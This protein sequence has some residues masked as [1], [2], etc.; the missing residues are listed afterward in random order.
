LTVLDCSIVLLKGLNAYLR[1]KEAL[2]TA[3]F[4]LAHIL[5][6]GNPL[7]EVEQ[8]AVFVETEKKETSSQRQ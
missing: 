7:L 8:T 3:G 4:H 5:L 1:G 6:S 2:I